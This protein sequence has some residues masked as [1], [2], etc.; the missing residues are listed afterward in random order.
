MKKEEIFAKVSQCASGTVL[1]FPERGPWGS[2]KYRGNFSGW[3]PA[4]LI[5]RYDAKS[6]SEIFAGG[7]TTSDLCKDLEIPYLGLDLNPN[8]VRNDIIAGDILDR[9]LELPDFFYE[10]DLQILHPP[11]PCI[12]DIHYSNSMWEGTGNEQIKDIQEM[13]WDKGM[14]AINKALM[15]GFSAMPSGSYQAVVV[16]DIRKKVDGKSVFHSMLRDLVFPGEVQQILVKM[17][18]NTVSGRKGGYNRKM[19]FFLIEHEFVV[20]TKKPSGYE[21]AYVLPREYSFDIRDSYDATWKDVVS[22]VMQKLGGQA[23][24]QQIYQE[25]EGHK[26]CANNKNWTA[27]IRQTLQLYAMFENISSGVWRMTAA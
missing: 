5:Y 9:N 21:I 6:V 10:A 23:T 3:I 1:S 15:K 7:G 12:N 22:S 17:Q 20:V 2:S 11:Y 13:S 19:P 25:I 16:G 4:S 18:H 26:K 27:K 14:L 8:P 24:L